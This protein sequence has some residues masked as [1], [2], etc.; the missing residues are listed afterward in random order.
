MRTKSPYGL[1]LPAFFSL[2]GAVTLVF[3]AWPNLD[4]V[5]HRWLYDPV[6]QTFPG[7]QVWLFQFMAQAVEWV[8]VLAVL[9][10]LPVWLWNRR[11]GQTWGGITGRVY[12]YLVLSLALG[13]GLVVNEIFKNHWGRARPRQIAEFGGTAEFT[14]PWLPTDQCARNCSFTS[15][16]ASVGFWLITVA[17]LL[18]DPWRTRA[19]WASVALGGCVGYARMAKG[20]HFFSD[21]VYSGLFVVLVARCVH[22]WLLAPQQRLVWAQGMWPRAAVAATP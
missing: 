7:Q 11:R 4:L 16:D 2:F 17:F 20:A 22:A 1:N 15:G 8:V 12:A 19:I 10:P 14:P 3:L 21:V 5:L 6:Q 9:L 18:P 13:P